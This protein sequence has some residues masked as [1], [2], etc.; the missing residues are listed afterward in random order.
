MYLPTLTRT[1]PCRGADAT[2][3]SL[4]KDIVQ[5]RELTIGT[6]LTSNII[7]QKTDETSKVPGIGNGNRGYGV[8]SGPGC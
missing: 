4:Q 1:A 6:N 5:L 2:R 7:E 8:G 3:G